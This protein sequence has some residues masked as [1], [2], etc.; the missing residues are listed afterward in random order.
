MNCLIFS[1]FARLSTISE[2]FFQ[3]LILSFILVKSDPKLLT[4]L[5]FFEQANFASVAEILQLIVTVALSCTIFLVDR[6]H[7]LAANAQNLESFGRRL[8]DNRF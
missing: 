1:P 5:I 3:T 4:F 7:V 2:N 6:L 8:E